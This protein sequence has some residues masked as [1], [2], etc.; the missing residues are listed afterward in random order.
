MTGLQR[1]VV[2]GAIG[3]HHVLLVGA[4]DA[5]LEAVARRLA[6]ILP[7]LLERERREVAVVRE[8]AGFT[9]ADYPTR[10]AHDDRPYRSPHY[11]LSPTGMAGGRHPAACSAFNSLRISVGEITLAHHGVLMLADIPMFSRAALEPMVAAMR[12]RIVT[13]GRGDVSRT[14]PADFQLVATSTDCPCGRPGG[15][16]HCDGRDRERWVRRLRQILAYVDMV[17]PVSRADADALLELPVDVLCDRVRDGRRDARLRGSTDGGII[18][19]VNGNRVGSHWS[20][21]N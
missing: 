16:C 9:A 20:Q 1:A 14:W 17:I 21:G 10:A 2:A 15:H 12:D 19:D 4:A 18:R 7:P 8:A 5:R 6:E 13:V 11:T 3:R